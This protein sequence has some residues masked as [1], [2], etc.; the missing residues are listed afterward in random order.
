MSQKT[1]VSDIHNLSMFMHSVLSTHSSLRI[2]TVHSEQTLHLS[3]KFVLSEL[4]VCSDL[5]FKETAI[6]CMHRIK[7]GH[8]QYV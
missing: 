3:A 2:H 1:L 4:C 7:A 5:D 6:L 8:A